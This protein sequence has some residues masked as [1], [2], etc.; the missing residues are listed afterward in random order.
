LHLYIPVKKQGMAKNK[1][2]FLEMDEL[3]RIAGNEEDCPLC[4]LFLTE[5]EAGKIR[6]RDAQIFSAHMDSREHGIIPPDKVKIS[7]DR[8]DIARAIQ[9]A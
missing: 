7:S 5:A 2:N 1:D 3:G 4:D 8:A 6:E 9:L